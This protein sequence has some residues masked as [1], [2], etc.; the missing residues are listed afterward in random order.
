MAKSRLNVRVLRVYVSEYPYSS[1]TRSQ[2]LLWVSSCFSDPAYCRQPK[3]VGS[4]EN[5]GSECDIVLEVWLC[6]VVMP[7]IR[8]SCTRRTPQNIGCD[9]AG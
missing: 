9:P 6:L 8:S 1:C 2:A 4:Y 3:V 5:V 7:R